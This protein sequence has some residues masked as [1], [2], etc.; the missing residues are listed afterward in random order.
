ME[1]MNN[2]L[3][4]QSLDLVAQFL[5]HFECKNT[6]QIFKSEAHYQKE[7]QVNNPK[8]ETV[9]EFINHKKSKVRKKFHK[10]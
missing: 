7:N 10:S 3:C 8:L 1:K 2:P 9:L 4:V 6:M 5:E